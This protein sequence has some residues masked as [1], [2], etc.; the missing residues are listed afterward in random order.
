MQIITP[1]LLGIII[2]AIRIKI[3]IIPG[4][5][6]CHNNDKYF[7]SVESF[8]AFNMGQAL[9]GAHCTYSL[10][11][12][13]YEHYK[14][15]TICYPPLRWENLAPGHPSQEGGT[16]PRSACDTHLQQP[17]SGRAVPNEVRQC[18][19]GTESLA[20]YWGEQKSG[21]RGHRWQPRWRA[22]WQRRRRR[23]A[24]FTGTLT[25]TLP[26]RLDAF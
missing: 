8:A 26:T 14:V 25:F 22:G 23:R 12:F 2:S 15:G 21:R 20:G 13:L 10:I 6:Y 3:I 9:F 5:S 18:E 7:C 24:A 16:C 17:P 19:E 1:W 11:S 4:C